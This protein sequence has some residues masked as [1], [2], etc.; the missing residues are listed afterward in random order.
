MHLPSFQGLVILEIMETFFHDFSRGEGLIPCMCLELGV[1]VCN[2]CIVALQYIMCD[3]RSGT[4]WGERGGFAWGKASMGHQ[5]CWYIHIHMGAHTCFMQER[6]CVCVCVPGLVRYQGN[7]CAG[8]IRESPAGGEAS[9]AAP[10]QPPGQG[11]VCI[12][13]VLALDWIV[14][15]KEVCVCAC[16]C[17]YISVSS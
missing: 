5:A 7:G 13:A 4:K 11:G 15:V 9:E 17:V 14:V 6:I 2:C 3:N 16:M 1:N 8:L 12:C 10:W